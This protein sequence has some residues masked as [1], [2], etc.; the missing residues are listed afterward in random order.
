M[1]KKTI[2]K[3]LSLLIIALASG[4]AGIIWSFNVSPKATWI[5]LISGLIMNIL[6]LWADKYEFKSLL[7]KVDVSIKTLNT[8]L[9]NAGFNDK[10][11]FVKDVPVFPDMVPLKNDNP[12]TE[13]PGYQSVSEE[14]VDQLKENIKEVVAKPK[15][16]RGPKPTKKKS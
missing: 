4:V 11:E 1:E 9:K 16:K 5:I 12:C 8:E 15:K 6:K 10:V 13:C 14:V 3:R 7:D 2:F